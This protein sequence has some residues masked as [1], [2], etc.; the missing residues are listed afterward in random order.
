MLPRSLVA[1]DLPDVLDTMVLPVHVLAQLQ[2]G[3]GRS[4]AGK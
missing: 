2:V 1:L 3:F 4:H